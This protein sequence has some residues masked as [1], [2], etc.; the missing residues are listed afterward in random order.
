MFSLS[1]FSLFSVTVAKN[2]TKEN[3]KDENK[4]KDKVNDKEDKEKNEDKEKEKEKRKAYNIKPMSELLYC[5]YVDYF[6]TQKEDVTERLVVAG[7]LYL[8]T[9][10]CIPPFFLPCLSSLSDFPQIIRAICLF[11][12][13]IVSSHSLILIFIFLL[14]CILIQA[15]HLLIFILI[16]LL[17]CILIQ[18]KQYSFFSPLNLHPH[19]PAPLYSIQAKQYC[20][21]ENILM[22]S[23]LT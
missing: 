20:F 22:T 19:L 18:A 7:N 17:L 11:S 6:G 4:D 16:L 14:L 10:T 21:S 5:S 12:N 23:F 2:K 15:K 13:S 1:S 3:D 9:L 8:N